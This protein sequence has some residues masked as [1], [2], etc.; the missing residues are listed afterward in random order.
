MAKPAIEKKQLH[1]WMIS[2]FKHHAYTF[3]APHPRNFAAFSC[4]SSTGWD[5]W[6]YVK[7]NKHSAIPADFG[8]DLEPT[9]WKIL[10]HFPTAMWYWQNIRLIR[11]EDSTYWCH[12]LGILRRPN[13]PI[14]WNFPD[15]WRIP[16]K[17][18]AQIIPVWPIGQPGPCLGSKCKPCRP[19]QRSL[20]MCHPQARLNP[21]T[22]RPAGSI[23][24]VHWRFLVEMSE[25][26]NM[27]KWNEGLRWM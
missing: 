3:M 10:E 8:T 15:V 12:Y 26:W 21:F 5:R 2:L 9:S 1:F 25:L 6:E 22:A 4:G 19:C 16:K 18:Q 7:K 13:P 11:S 27:L 23:R 20:S 14:I 17:F 24:W